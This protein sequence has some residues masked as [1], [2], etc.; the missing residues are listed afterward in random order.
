MVKRSSIVIYK[1]VTTVRK[2][3]TGKKKKHSKKQNMLLAFSNKTDILFFSWHCYHDV[4]HEMSYIF[5]KEA[6]TS[7]L[8]GTQFS[9][10]FILWYVFLG[11]TDCLTWTTLDNFVSYFCFTCMTSFLLASINNC[12]NSDNNILAQKNMSFSLISH[13]MNYMLM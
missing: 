1:E 2:N 13:S 12:G 10:L 11:L 9:S 8:L 5:W 4:F 3:V 7:I 6:K